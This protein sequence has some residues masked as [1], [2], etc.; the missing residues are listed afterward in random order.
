MWMLILQDFTIAILMQALPTSAKSCRLGY[1]I[2]SMYYL[3]HKV[4]PSQVAFLLECS[5]EWRGHG[6]QG[7]YAASG[8]RLSHERTC[9][10]MKPLNG[11]ARLIKDGKQQTS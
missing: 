9:S 1:T 3:S 6:S 5:P 10:L 2:S 4:L 7:S 8:S 11:S